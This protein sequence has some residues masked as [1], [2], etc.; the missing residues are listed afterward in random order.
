LRAYLI[1]FGMLLALFGAIAAFLYQQFA[2]MA[3]E[4]RTPPP[5]TIAASVAETRLWPETLQATG[6][7]R[8]AQGA[9]LSTQDSGEVIAV[10]ARSGAQVAVGQRLLQLNNRGELARQ[11]SQRA[12]LKLA[13]ILF[14]RDQQLLQQ[15]S[16]PQT[17]FDRSRADLDVARANLAETEALLMNKQL[18]APFAGTL[19]IVTARVGDYLEAGD[20]VASLQDFSRLEVDFALPAQH[21]PRLRPGLPITLQVAGIEGQALTAELTAIDSQVDP[22]T[23]TLLIRATLNPANGLLPGMFATVTIDL[24]SAQTLVSVRET[25]IT[26]STSGDTVYV[27]EAAEGGLIATPRIVR[28]GPSADGYIAI[29]N[30]LAEGERIAIAGQNKLY[31]GAPVQLDEQAPL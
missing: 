31:R 28:T 3:A 15:K 2:G 11:E 1:V 7:I 6:T 14:Q 17:Q 9:A 25:A 29:V 16:I 8:A 5:I 19:G 27:I 10:D 4:D 26:Y 13:E 20:N 18:L 22:E 12:A 21:A 30:G 23:R 24:Q